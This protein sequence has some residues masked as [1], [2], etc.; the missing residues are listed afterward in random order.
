[1][2]TSYIDQVLFLKHRGK[3]SCFF[4]LEMITIF[5]MK[6]EE[7]DRSHPVNR[8]NNGPPRIVTFLSTLFFCFE[9]LLKLH[10]LRLLERALL[11]VIPVSHQIIVMSHEVIARAVWDSAYVLAAS[12][13][14]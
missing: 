6:G 8:F 12:I 11:L 14:F 5:G 2:G 3:L 10:F 4:E 7:G 9:S 13:V 1:M